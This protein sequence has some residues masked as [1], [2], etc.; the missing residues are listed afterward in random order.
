MQRATPPTI[1]SSIRPAAKHR[2]RWGG[3]AFRDGREDN[4]QPLAA[5]LFIAECPARNV[6]KS[7][8]MVLLR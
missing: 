5:G 3:I 8:K 7:R 1:S 6:K 4:G 2:Y